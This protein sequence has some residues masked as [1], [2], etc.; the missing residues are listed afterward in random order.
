[1][2]GRAL[3]G[4][5]GLLAVAAGAWSYGHSHGYSAGYQA[6]VEAKQQA[7]DTARADAS[8]A[9]G[10][11]TTVRQELADVRR[12]YHLAMQ[13]AQQTIAARDAE[14]A[15]LKQGLQF[16]LDE[17]N[18]VAKQWQDCETLAHDPVCAPVARRLW[19]AAATSTGHAG[20]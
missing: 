14:V 6:A 4:V 1:M 17:I 3:I 19:P 10:A 12:N 11:L 13:A 2:M 9:R 8:D 16:K 7:I 20:D 18:H 5:A 15:H